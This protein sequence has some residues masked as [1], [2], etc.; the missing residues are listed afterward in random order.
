MQSLGYIPG[1]MRSGAFRTRIEDEVKQ[2]GEIV[3]KANI[4][5]E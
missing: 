5:R 1:G 4:S 2:W 3:S